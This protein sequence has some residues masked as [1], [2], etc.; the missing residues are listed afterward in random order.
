MVYKGEPQS[1]HGTPPGLTTK[2]L[3]R[4]APAPL[5]A[6]CVLIYPASQPWRARS[7]TTRE[8]RDRQGAEIAVRTV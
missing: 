5:Q 7:H 3:L 2:L 6:F 8:L 4:L 1:Y